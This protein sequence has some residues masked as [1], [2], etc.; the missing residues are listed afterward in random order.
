MGGASKSYY[1]LTYWDMCY[2][3]RERQL[4]KAGFRLFSSIARTDQH[5]LQ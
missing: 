4:D 2:E 5:H 1:D 3:D